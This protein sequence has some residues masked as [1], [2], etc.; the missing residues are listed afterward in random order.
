MSSLSGHQIQ[1]SEKVQSLIQ[2]LV[3]EVT[4]LNSSLTS[5]RPA[6]EEFKASS[7]QKIASAGQFRG[8]AS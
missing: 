3:D 7:Q 8:R 5:I 6:L 4:R 2:Q 1:Q